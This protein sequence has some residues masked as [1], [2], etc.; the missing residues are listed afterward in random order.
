MGGLLPWKGRLG[1]ISALERKSCWHHSP[2]P[3]RA[4][5]QH[6]SLA[7][8]RCSPIHLRGLW[9]VCRRSKGRCPGDTDV[10]TMV[11]EQVPRGKVQTEGRKGWRQAG[12]V[13]P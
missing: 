6:A 3:H 5:T 7:Q 12:M 2:S 9:E 10:G 8:A 11:K 13:S 1:M 4:S